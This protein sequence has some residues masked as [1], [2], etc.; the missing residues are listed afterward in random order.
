MDFYLIDLLAIEAVVFHVRESIKSFV[1]C[2]PLH[3]GRYL[4]MK[5]NIAH[6]FH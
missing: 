2:I 3:H 1:I 4:S 6:L 5:L